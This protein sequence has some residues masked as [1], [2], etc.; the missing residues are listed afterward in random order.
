MAA[1]AIL[2][3]FYWLTMR[4]GPSAKLLQNWSFR[5]GDFRCD[6]SIFQDGGHPPSRICFGI[7]WTTH[8]EYMD[9]GIY[10][11]AKF[12]YDQCSTF[13]NMEVS[14][15]GVNGWKTPIYAS[16]PQKRG[17]SAIRV[18]YGRNPKK[19]HPCVSLHH[20]SH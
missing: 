8:E 13:E 16:P 1:A 15:F 3:K 9:G 2:T 17:S 7:I 19:A 5:C 14:I 20:L 11:C 10:H 12:G 18:R 4:K 6:F